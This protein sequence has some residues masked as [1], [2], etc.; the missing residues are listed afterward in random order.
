MGENVKWE[1][2]QWIIKKCHQA[3]VFISPWHSWNILTSADKEQEFSCRRRQPGPAGSQRG[4]RNTLSLFCPCSSSSLSV[5][6]SPRISEAKPLLGGRQA[7]SRRGICVTP[8]SSDCPGHGRVTV[9]SPEHVAYCAS[10][11]QRVS[12]WRETV[13]GRRVLSL[14]PQNRRNTPAGRGREGD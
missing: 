14:F 13:G 8:V 7:I 6:A 1:H 11:C 3:F 9:L 4:L 2:R 12:E 5:R 10:V